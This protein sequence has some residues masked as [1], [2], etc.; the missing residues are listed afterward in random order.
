MRNAFGIAP[1]QSGFGQFRKILGRGL[2]V[3]NDFLRI[4]IFQFVEGEIA[5]PGNAH[6]FVQHFRRINFFQPRNRAQVALSAG[7]QGEPGFCNRHAE[8][9]RSQ[10]V[11]K[12]AASARVHVHVAAGCTGQPR[13]PAE[14]PECGK[15]FAVAA[16]C[17]QFNGYPEPCGEALREPQRIF[18]LR[19][20]RRQPERKAMGD[21]G[22]EMAAR[23]AVFALGS[24]APTLRD[25]FGQIAVAF[26]VGCEQYKAQ[27]ILEPELGADDQFE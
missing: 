27:S 9:D 24:I 22:F 19:L 4:L 23:E 26:A 6:G 13:L 2:A 1:V 17:Q 8:P 5:Q 10:R 15:A 12:R 11:L 20:C 3:R 7:L 21:A 16:S 25:Q 14:F 18:S